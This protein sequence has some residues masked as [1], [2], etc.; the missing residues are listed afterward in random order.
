MPGPAGIKGWGQPVTQEPI[1]CQGCGAALPSLDAVCA[2]C[3]AEL[4]AV[5][6]SPPAKYSCPHC[7]QR[8]AAAAQVLWPPKVPWWRPTTFRL[9]CPHC[10]GLLRDDYQGAN[11]VFLVALLQLVIVLSESANR[12]RGLWMPTL[13]VVAALWLYWRSR[14]A[15]RDPQRYTVGTQHQWLRDLRDLWRN[16]KR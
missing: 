14:Q 15:A 12:H 6:P 7:Q 4:T 3:E 8:F 11:I 16:S 9:Q 1:H 5:P 10:E 13:Y 2:T